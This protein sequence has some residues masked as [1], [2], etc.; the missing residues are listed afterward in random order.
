MVTDD[1]Q[2]KIMDFGLAKVRG[3]AQVTK[4][5]T[6]LGT[7]AYMSPEQARGE[8]ADHRSDIWAFGVVL[9]EMLT[10]RFPFGGDY[11]QAVMYSIMN[12]EPDYPDEIPAHLKEVLQK[13]LAK[14]L[15][16]RY[17]HIN[18]LLA[19]LKA[20]VKDEKPDESK[21][22]VVKNRPQNLV[23]LLAGAGLLVLILAAVFLWPF[24]SEKQ[25]IQSL[26]VLPLDNLSGDPAQDYFSDGMTEALITHLSKI[27]ALKVIS[28]TSVM[29]FKNSTK[30]L[31]E[32]AGEL[33][34]D[35]VI[36]GSV[37]RAGDQIRITAQLIEAATDRNLWADS[38][39]R[40]LTDVFALQRD[41]AQTIAEHI[42]VTLTPDEQKEF[43]VA[44]E[45][46]PEAYEAYL[47]GIYH[48]SKHKPSDFL[49][50]LEYF[51]LAVEIEPEFT[52][53]YLGIVT[54]CT[55]MMDIGPLSFNELYPKAKAAM[56]KAFMLDNALA[57]V[58]GTQ[59]RFK[60]MAE[61]D[62]DG[63]EMAFKKSLELN[64]S[65]SKTYYDYAFFLVS[66]GREDEAMSM[67]TKARTLD[68]L[69]PDINSDMGWFHFLFRRYEDAIR[70]YHYNLDM[71]PDY[72]MSIRE[73][74]WAYAKN[75]MYVEAIQ[76]ALKAVA[77]ERSVYNL[78]QLG[79]VYAI[80]GQPDEAYK[81]T[82]EIMAAQ[83]SQQLPYY[84]LS[85]LYGNLG[86]LDEAYKWL[87]KAYEEHTGWPFFI[88]FDPLADPL[89]EDPRYASFIK[90]FG[91]EP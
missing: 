42:R 58:Y 78:L 44:N 41:I 20:T 40:N 38:Y 69:S 60:H 62:W 9:Y 26:A 68:P 59:G 5:G 65:V 75:S 46:D 67:L 54:A 25:T 1:G 63:A 11:E 6:T 53:A 48:D 80:S 64:P 36:D 19:D 76:F 7:A 22:G 15:N 90:R 17:Q 83:K 61:W 16:D 86:D 84:E 30:S 52:L 35:A 24:G 55:G 34:V 18:E 81:L 13:A 45:I 43:E 23:Y 57:E 29:Q 51:T 10:G 70:E 39:E 79:I 37:M 32:I 47:K 72:E 73:L 89:R 3:G 88:K 74:G 33:G 14:N 2:V 27:S 82:D 66:M 77:L 85:L 8:D 71:Y 21:T 91:F 87:E 4:A 50:G 56:D 49:K 28:R 12:E 31:P